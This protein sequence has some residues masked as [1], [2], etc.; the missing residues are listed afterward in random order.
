MCIGLEFHGARRSWAELIL[1]GGIEE[2]ADCRG[3]RNSLPAAIHLWALCVGTNVAYQASFLAATWRET[4]APDLSRFARGGSSSPRAP[5]S[6]TGDCI[7]K[8]FI[9]K[10]RQPRLCR[11]LRRGATLC[12][13]LEL[14]H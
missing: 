14:A 10:V 1:L 5:V 6:S 11:G 8:F 9:E 2:R 4:G 7:L 13:R 12:D 3:I